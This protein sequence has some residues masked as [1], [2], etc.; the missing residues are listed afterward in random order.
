MAVING[1]SGNDTSTGGGDDDTIT[2]GAGRDTLYGA[3]GVDTLNG[4]TGNDSLFGGSDRDW[5]YAG[6]GNDAAFG[7][8]EGDRLF[9]GNG[10]DRLWGGIGDDSLEGGEGG[11]TLGGGGDDDTLWGGAGNDSL[12]GDDGDDSLAGGSGN[13]SLAG[14]A[15]V[16]LL[17][18]GT[19]ND[20]LAGGDDE[21]TLTG[22]NGDDTVTAAAGEDVLWGGAGRDTL[23]GGAD[24]DS[25]F[26]G[27]SN[28]V[29]G[30][31]DGAGTLDGG[32]GADTLTGG[33]GT[34]TL[35]GGTGNDLY[36][37]TTGNDVYADSDGIDTLRAGV[38]VTLAA[39]FENL[40]FTGT[41]ALTGTGNDLANRLT[42]NSAANRLYGLD[43]D[44]ILQGGGGNDSLIGGNGEDTA[45][46]SG[47]IDGY[48]ISRVGS[49]ITV[50]DTDTTDGNDGRD[51]LIGI[52]RLEFA[53]RTMTLRPLDLDALVGTEMWS[54]QLLVNQGGAQGGSEG[55]FGNEADVVTL[56]GGT[57]TTLALALGDL[58]GDG[59]LDALLG[60]YD[61]GNWLL[62]NQGG[63]QGGSEGSFGTEADI[64]SLPG[65]INGTQAVALGDL[66]GDG[67]LDALIGKYLEENQLLVNQGGAQGGSEGSF[68]TEA[69]V[70][71]L[72]GGIQNTLA[73][74]L[75][76]LDGDGDLDAVLGNYTNESHFLVNQGGLQGG[77]EGDFL[78]GATVPGGSEYTTAVALGDLDG[79]GTGGLTP[80]GLPWLGSKLPIAADIDWTA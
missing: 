44:D 66:D 23:S 40:E 20:L 67:D 80:S 38:T 25:L 63:A 43:G 19:G 12:S 70:V 16:G 42:G 7:D 14:G 65:G 11:D 46:F 48:A 49:L 57:P 22:G 77:N 32:G 5:L 50:T 61:Q 72:P 33:S 6:D 8:G 74:A 62:V 24:E 45:V 17:D 30:G 69:D 4:G 58:D 52:E 55:S 79:D 35:W 9:G 26:G 10:T 27:S 29:L 54:N 21:D 18:G 56:P 36:I 31:G 71:T 47:A 60:N 28:D 68:G 73:V 59:D 2:T 75:G 1:T 53:D 76:D 15:G 13:D 51:R 34:D 3:A 37:V 41:A 78:L 64:V 39:F